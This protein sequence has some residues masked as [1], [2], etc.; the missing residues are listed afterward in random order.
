MSYEE[1]DFAFGKEPDILA[2][3]EPLLEETL[4]LA[5]HAL[6]PEERNI[7]VQGLLELHAQG[8]LA[9]DGIFCVRRDA[10]LLG[11]MFSQARDEKTVL[12]W[13]PGIV[14]GEEPRIRTLLYERMNRHLEQIGAEIAIVFVENGESSADVDL[15]NAGFRHLSDLLYLVA[16]ETV[17]PME[18]GRSLLAFVPLACAEL[19]EPG[20]ID[21]PNKAFRE[22]T[23]LVGRTYEGT[24][25]FPELCGVVPTE[26]ILRG[27]QFEG[28]VRPELWFSVRFEGKNIGSLILTDQPD[29]QHLELT[30]MGIVPEER[31][32]RYAQA[33][34]QYALYTA[35]RLNRRLLIVSVD[36][37][38]EAALRAYLRSGFQV[39]DKKRLFVRFFQEEKE[40]AGVQKPESPLQ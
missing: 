5:F 30:Y 20:E 3:S 29:M 22:M 26:E 38:N 6:G 21:I 4:R 33:I 15:E 11:A 39:W 2:C 25:D 31:G 34:V 17:F 35:R 24:R 23:E 36:A 8:K 37:Q 19:P 16:E 14:A 1:T 10:Q 27:Y 28:V 32:K 40:R 18:P 13:P 7:R 12:I 9:L